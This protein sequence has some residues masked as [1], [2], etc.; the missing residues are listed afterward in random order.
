MSISLFAAITCGIGSL[1]KIAILWELE[2]LSEIQ[3]GA[4]NQTASHFC[5][6]DA[7]DAASND[8][9]TYI[10]AVA[11][12]DTHTGVMKVIL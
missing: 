10:V 7:Q 6:V 4:D 3:L 2:V 12:A 11:D 1:E 8:T 5:A 9:V